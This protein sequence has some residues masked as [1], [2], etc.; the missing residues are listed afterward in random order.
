M[1][2][3]PPIPQVLPFTSILPMGLISVSLN[4]LTLVLALSRSLSLFLYR[5]A[6]HQ[7]DLWFDLDKKKDQI[8]VCRLTWNG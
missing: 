4:L 5:Q 8:K 2:V 6:K 1:N 3:Y 7:V